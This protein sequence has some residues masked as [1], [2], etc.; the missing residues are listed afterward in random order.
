MSME[1]PRILMLTPFQKTQR[2]N[3]VTSIRLQSGLRAQGF[4]VDI[5]SMEDE[6]YHILLAKAINSEKYGLIH[7]FHAW[8]CGQALAAVPEMKALPLLLTTTGT[9][10]HYDLLGQGRSSVLAAFNTAQKIV[11]FNEDFRQIILDNYPEVISKLRTIPQGVV[12]AEGQAVSRAQ[13]GI[14]EQQ[15]VFLLPSGLRPVKNIEMSINALQRLRD[16]YPQIHLLILGTVFDAQYSQQLLQRIKELEWVSYCGEIVHEN[17]KGYLLLGDVVLN[18]SH[19]EGQPQGA[20]E[21]M[22]L[23][24]PCILSAVPGNLNLITAGVEGFYVHS[25]DELF[26]YAEKLMND[27]DLYLRMGL[28]ACQLVESKFAPEMEIQAYDQLY[29]EI[30]G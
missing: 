30:L 23:G 6:N 7:A 19:A 14:A 15:F 11:V 3:S 9:D 5:L 1:V 12:L 25:E 27:Y 8:H 2:G 17:M 26:I 13:L 21:A 16:I 22:S 24:K 29:Q 4:K 20:L 10:L 18:T 28:A